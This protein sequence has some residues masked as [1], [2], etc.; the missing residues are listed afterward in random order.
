MTKLLNMRSSCRDVVKHYTRSGIII[1]YGFDE[2][3]SL[4][5]YIA[6]RL[7]TDI[8]HAQNMSHLTNSNIYYFN[9]C[10]VTIGTDCKIDDQSATFEQLYG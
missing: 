10:T 8:A 5:N 9:V 1:N 3:I 6:G 4:N 7:K 2:K